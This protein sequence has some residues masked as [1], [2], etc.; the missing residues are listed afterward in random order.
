MEKNKRYI[1]LIL[2]IIFIIAIIWKINIFKTD[3]NNFK[4]IE[5]N[6]SINAVQNEMSGEYELYDESGN[7]IQTLQ[8]D[9]MVDI[10]KTDPSYNPN[11]SF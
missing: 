2:G 11:P 1:L 8:D 5:N 7:L 4:E 6:Q 10:Y 3:K 9:S